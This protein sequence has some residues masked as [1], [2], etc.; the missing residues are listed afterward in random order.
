VGIGGFSALFA[1]FGGHG[2]S[3]GALTAAIVVGPDAQPD[4]DRRY[5]SAV[6]SGVWHIAFGMFGA[7]VVD[8]F[9]IFPAV[10]VSTIAG[11]SLSGVLANSLSGALQHTEYRDAGIV[12]FLCTAGDFA[13]FGIGAPFWGLVAGVAVHALMRWRVRRTAPV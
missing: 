3:L 1:P 12:A 4:P 2:L 9:A 10:F 6:M 5:A 8:L 7:A 13:L 11:L